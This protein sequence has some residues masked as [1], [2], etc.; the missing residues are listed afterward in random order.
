MLSTQLDC[1]QCFED[2][3]RRDVYPVSDIIKLVGGMPRG[4]KKSALEKLNSIGPL[5]KS[6]PG[7]DESWETFS[8]GTE[9]ESASTHKRGAS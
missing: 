2:I 6:W 8:V 5:Q 7:G 3:G 1:F 4:I 9:R